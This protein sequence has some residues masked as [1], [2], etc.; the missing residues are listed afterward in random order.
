MKTSRAAVLTQYEAPLEL[1]E[2]PL[3]QAIEP[4]AALVRVKLAG[5][6]GTDVHLWHGQLPIPLPVILGHETVGV[7]DEMGEGLTH[8][9]TG[10]PL[11]VGDRIGWSSSINCNEC[12][13]CRTKPQP[14]RCLKRKAYGIS[15]DCSLA[16]HL[17]GGYADYIYLRPG[18][19]IFKIP[20]KLPTEA[21]VGAG[22]ALVTSLHGAERIGVQM[23][24]TVVIQGSGPVGLASLAV[25][26]ASGAALTIVLGG[27]PHRLELAKRFGA[28]VCIDVAQ[29]SVEERK[30]RVLELSGGFGVDLVLECVGIPEAVVEG[31][32]LCR[33][34][35]RYLVLGHYGNAGTIEFNPHV[36]TRKQLVVAGSWGFEPRHTNAAL[37][38]LARTREQFPF[39]QLVAKP[40]PLERA[41]EA[42]QAT[43]AWTTAKSAIAP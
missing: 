8:D 6:C 30:A 32:E 10:A 18:T 43:A 17:L 40:F 14:T 41:F 37:K 1:K 28:D 35:G 15:Y 31:V 19:A 4:G 24:D 33:D 13:Y 39:E 22:C 29:T 42:L 26:K 25:A 5:I 21:V 12:F 36:I 23:G 38:F 16:P 9:W 7:I 20:E 34:G 11:A 27:P 2:F 3:P